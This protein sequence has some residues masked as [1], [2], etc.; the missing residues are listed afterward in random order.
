MREIVSPLD[1]IRSPFR[2]QR[3]VAITTIAMTGLTSGV[4][5]IGSH[6]SIS[7]GV[8]SGVTSWTS[9]SWG[10]AYGDSTYGT[11]ANPTTFA[12]GN[13]GSL[14]WQGVGNDGKTYRATAPIRYPVPVLGTLTNQTINSDDIEPT[15]DIGGQVTFSG[16]P[17]YSLP[18]VPSEGG[19]SINSSGV[20]AFDPGILVLQTGTT[21]TARV[22]DAV[23][24]TRFAERSFTLTVEETTTIV[25]TKVSEDFSTSS[26]ELDI[27]YSSGAAETLFWEFDESPAQPV[28]GAGSFG[29]GTAGTLGSPSAVN[30]SAFAT[31]TGYL[32]ISAGAPLAS[33]TLTYG[34]FEVPAGGVPIAGPSDPFVNG[35]LESFWTF[36]PHDKSGGVSPPTLAFGTTG[37]DEYLQITIPAGQTYDLFDTTVPNSAPLVTQDWDGTSAFDIRVRLLT[38]PSVGSNLIGIVV[39]DTAGAGWVVAELYVA[40]G[41]VNAYCRRR[42]ADNGT[43]ADI[44]DVTV[45]GVDWLRLTRNA[46]GTVWAFFTSP[47]GTTW[48]QRGSNFSLGPTLVAPNKIGVFAGS[49][50]D[51]FNARFDS[52]IEEL[53]DSITDPEGSEP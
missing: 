52:F 16:T 2:R 36:T 29:S 20:I 27:A 13:G 11:G 32:H 28:R 42:R 26:P 31:Q 48:T 18:V 23:D 30:L 51:G 49:Y 33:N 41:V 7:V 8:P 50:G 40:S 43:Y 22:A 6:A 46:G 39:H 14:Q 35:V 44:A 15:Y 9:Q 1:G 34:P 45:T 37:G 38:I 17:S 53:T 21:I 24:A 47:D 12:A 4:A 25:L 3:G 10:T 19:A 5:E